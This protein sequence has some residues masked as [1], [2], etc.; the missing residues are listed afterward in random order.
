MFKEVCN[1]EVYGVGYFVEKDVSGIY[2][3]V[4]GVF[5]FGWGYYYDWFNIEKELCEFNWFGYLVEFDFY[6][7]KL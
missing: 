7:F 1:Y 4:I 2:V 3:D 6:S 5:W